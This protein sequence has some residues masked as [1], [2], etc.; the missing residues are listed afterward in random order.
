MNI[1]PD[2]NCP[3]CGWVIMCPHTPAVRY[4]PNCIHAAPPRPDIE[5]TDS[6]M[7]N[8]RR[9]KAHPEI[10]DEMWRWLAGVPA[11]DDWSDVI[12]A[13]LASKTKAPRPDAKASSS[14]RAIAQ[15][16]RNP[17]YVAAG[18]R[19]EL[20]ELAATREGSR[21]AVLAK[22]ACAVFEF[23][24]AGHADQTATWDELVRI[25]LASGLEP[26]EIKSTLTHQWNKVGPRDVPAPDLPIRVI[27]C[28]PEQL[29]AAS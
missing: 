28:T 19:K 9:I 7:E 13:A 24:K 20:N 15:P 25:A 4:P 6:F 8:M 17:T 18:I 21:N 2:V 1:A 16:G 29:G 5:W 22:V 26:T 3:H 23:V 12:N 27:D 10:P 11:N 14:P